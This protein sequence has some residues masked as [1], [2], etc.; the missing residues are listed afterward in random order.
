MARERRPA[1]RAPRFLPGIRELNAIKGGDGIDGAMPSG[2]HIRANW[3]EQRRICAAEQARL[4]D[5]AQETKKHLGDPQ[6]I[7]SALPSIQGH[8]KF[9]K[10]VGN[11]SMPQRRNAKVIWTGKTG[12]SKS[13]LQVPDSEAESDMEDSL[14]ATASAEIKIG[15]E[16]IGWY[17]H[18]DRDSS[19]LT[20]LS[21][22]ELEYLNPN[23]ERPG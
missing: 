20:E 6:N 18:G 10:A 11:M 23:K 21:D 3:A 13:E 14:T 19:V 15:K 4:S 22:E 12:A 9:T 1:T 5:K 8:S 2:T 17:D 16:R 7:T